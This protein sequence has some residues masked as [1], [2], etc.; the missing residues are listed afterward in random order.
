MTFLSGWSDAVL[1]TLGFFWMAFWAFGLGYAISAAI[2]V[3]VSRAAMQRAMGRQGARSVALATF[4]GFISSSCSFAALAATRSFLAKGAGLVPALAFLLSSTNLVIELGIVISVFLSWHFVVAEYV[5]GVLLIAA[6]WII[7]RLTRPDRLIR[8]MRDRLEA[9]GDDTRWPVTALWRDPRVWGVLA[10][11]YL[12]EWRMVWKD[13]T[14]G[15][16][17]A[18]VIAAF[19]PS[20]FFVWLFPGTG[21]AEPLGFAEVL[22]QAVIGPVAA[23]FT[24]IGSMGNIPLAGLLY[25]NGVGVAGIMAFIFS[26]LI[27][28]PVLRV[29]ARFYGWRM[30]LYIAGVF[31]AA[32]VLTSVAIHYG[33]H[34]AG[35][36]PEATAR[37]LPEPESRFA[38]DYAFWLN[39][40]FA[41][42]SL[43]ALWGAWRVR[44]EGG[45]DHHHHHGGAGERLLRW[46]ALGCFGWL[47]GGLALALSGV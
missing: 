24:F 2:Q 11:S 12:G 34:L 28:L 5:G 10:Q 35:I 23:V 9:E 33:F 27:V 14:V 31:L 40:G 36:A 6:M 41:G 30:S 39:L 18:G 44:T 25:A 7:V 29:N 38:F 21:S 13:V 43:A 45:G 16:T 19:V 15:F 26:D 46:L 3:F 8:A 1:T 17:V 42:L 20:D 47:A 32:L 22:A 37:G 4:F